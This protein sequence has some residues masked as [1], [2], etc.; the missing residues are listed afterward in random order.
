MDAGKD[1]CDAY[2]ENRWCTSTGDYGTGWEPRSMGTFEDYRWNRETALVCP[3]CG[4]RE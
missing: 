1:N 4:C 3:Q 2:E